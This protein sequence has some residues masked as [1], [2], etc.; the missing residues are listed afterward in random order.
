MQRSRGAGMGRGSSGGNSQAEPL[1]SEGGKKQ[2]GEGKER[3]LASE[4]SSETAA[5]RRNLI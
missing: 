3:I 1:K 2:E 5:W 4:L